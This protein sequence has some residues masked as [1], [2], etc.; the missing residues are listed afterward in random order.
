MDW[1]AGRPDE[2][3]LRNACLMSEH[4][5]EPPLEMDSLPAQPS[6]TG[7]SPASHKL[8]RRDY[9]VGIC[10]L[11][12]V[13]FL[14]TTSNF[15]TEVRLRSHH[16]SVQCTTRMIAPRTCTT[17]DTVNL[18]CLCRPILDARPWLAHCRALQHHVPHNEHVF[19]VPPTIPNKELH[20]KTSRWS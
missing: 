3:G 13:V 14:W 7:K 12:L 2:P 19:A 5:L 8:S 15:V 11:L 16:R 17:G 9:A 1:R 6:A 18:S 10:L 4:H 20:S